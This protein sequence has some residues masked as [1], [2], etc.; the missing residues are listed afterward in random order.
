M[1]FPH[2]PPSCSSRT[3]VLPLER[4]SGFHASPRSLLSIKVIQQFNS[5]KL[6]SDQLNFRSTELR[7]TEL[8]STKLRS[9]QLLDQ[10][11]ALS[12]TSLPL[13]R[14]AATAESIATKADEQQKQPRQQQTS[15]PAHQQNAR[16]RIWTRNPRRDGP[17]GF[18][19]ACRARCWQQIVIL[20][21]AAVSAIPRSP[22]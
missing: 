3:I 18:A 20:T 8:R 9:T 2:A 17:L 1:L 16:G 22:R 21:A 19:P 7:S 12:N 6:N 10:D 4:K 11:T 13:N 14:Q 5:G 15:T